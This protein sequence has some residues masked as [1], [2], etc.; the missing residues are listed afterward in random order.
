MDKLLTKIEDALM[1]IGMLGALTVGTAQVVM[2]YVF[3]TGFVWSEIALVTLTILA[4][5]VGGSRAA[6]EGIHIRIT[7]L[8]ER[9]PAPVQRY[10]N[11]LAMTIALAYSLFMAYAAFLYVQFLHMT[12]MVSVEAHI[13]TWIIF[14]IAPLTM[15]LFSIRY[16]QRIPHAWRGDEVAKVEFID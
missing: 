5:L 1:L 2:R 12:G 4:A 3:N 7:V 9:L 13:P 15:A 10:A 14:S 11:T 8:T 16:I 6:A